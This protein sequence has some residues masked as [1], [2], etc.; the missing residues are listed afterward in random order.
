MIRRLITTL[1]LAILCVACA[2]SDDYDTSSA[3]SLPHG[4]YSGNET[5]PT[6]VGSI[7]DVT[8]RDASRNR[9]IVLT[10]DYP[11]TGGPH[12][13]IVFSHEYGGSNRAY[14]GLASYWARN[15]YVVIRPSHDDRGGVE[16]QSQGDWQNRTRDVLSVI[17]SLDTLEQRFPELQGKVDRARIGVA[18]HGHGGQTA[19]QLATDPRIKAVVAMVPETRGVTFANVAKPVL[20]ISGTRDPAQA[21]SEPYTLAPAGDKWLVAIENAR[22]Q[23]FT[24]RYEAFTEAQAREAARNEPLN[25][26]LQNREQQMRNTRVQTLMLR[27]QEMFGIVRGSALA[28][29]DA[30][31][32]GDA[33]ARTALENMTSRRGVSVERK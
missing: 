13:L 19:L 32:K 22:P 14:V 7:P 29:F 28:F 1:C 12:P 31:L 18:G 24:G 3:R 4:K 21:A 20:F 16:G 8:I 27:T 5:G 17:E 23:A 33:E 10:I 15:N 11:M 26:P 6:P 2:S 30:Y 9:D 25:D